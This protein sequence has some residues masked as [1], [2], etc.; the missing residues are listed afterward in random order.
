MS[1]LKTLSPI[2]DNYKWIFFDLDDTLHSFRA[3]ASHA[4]TCTFNTITSQH[5]HLNITDLQFTYKNILSTT[6]NPYFTDGKTSH[7]YRA[8]RFTAQLAE[9]DVHVNLQKMLDTYETSLL[10]ALALKP[11]ALSLLTALKAKGKHIAVV[12]EGPHDAQQRTINALNISPYIE[13]LATSNKSGISKSDGL[14]TK[15]AQEL[16]VSKEEVLVVGDDWY[17]D[18]TSAAKE[19]FRVVWVDERGKGAG[20]EKEGEEVM[21]IF[22][23]LRVGELGELFDRKE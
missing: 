19:G 16:G 18:V 7:E 14:F 11:Y 20:R 3:A 12:T 13:H 1:G 21:R 15:V 9:Y 23:I 17:R 4:A 22:E 5:P 6:A 10:E 8:A 2:F